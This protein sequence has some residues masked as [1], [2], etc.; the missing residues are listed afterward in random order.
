MLICWPDDDKDAL[1]V[2]AVAFMRRRIM[3]AMLASA[4]LLLISALSSA[5]MGSLW[6]AAC[7]TSLAAIA[8]WIDRYRANR[9]VR[10]CLGI[11][12][13]VKNGLIRRY[14]SDPEFSSEVDNL[15]R[16]WSFVRRQTMHRDYGE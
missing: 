2:Y 6:L 16:G 12:Q 1:A 10:N 11:P 14:E 7:G 13:A 5:M 8:Y 4:G 15:I 3:R 9:F